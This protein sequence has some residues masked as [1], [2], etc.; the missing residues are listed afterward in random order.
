MV[1]VVFAVLAIVI[2]GAAAGVPSTA[3]GATARPAGYFNQGDDCDFALNP[4]F[5]G[6]RIVGRTINGT[7]EPIKLVH[8]AEGHGGTWDPFPRIILPSQQYNTWCNTGSRIPLSSAEIWLKYE[9]GNGETVSF[10]AVADTFNTVE[11]NGG[12]SCT[13]N[14]PSSAYSCKAENLAVARGNRTQYFQFVVSQR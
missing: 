11:G 7:G 1:S 9:L 2:L 12:H 4:F 10:H 13:L 8:H 3:T 5:S 14:G 6:R